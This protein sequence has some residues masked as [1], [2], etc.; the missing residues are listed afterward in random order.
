MLNDAISYEEAERGR[1]HHP[2]IASVVDEPGALFTG[3]VVE[4]RV[5]RPCGVN[6]AVYFSQMDADGG[7]SRAGNQ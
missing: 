7:A 3:N 6:G 2:R 1:Q 5:R 4:E